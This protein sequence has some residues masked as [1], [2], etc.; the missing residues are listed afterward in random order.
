M[1]GSTTCE[2]WYSRC[3]I[4]RVHWAKA[5]LKKAALVDQ[6]RRGVIRIS[7]QGRQVVTENP[8]RVDMKY[9]ERF[10]AYAAW[11][12]GKI[13][14][15]I[16]DEP[17]EDVGVVAQTPE[18]RIETAYQELREA[19]AEDLLQQVKECS[20]KFF[21]RLV[22]ELLV[23][24]GY[25][26]S[27]EDAGKAV[28]R[29]GDGGIDG[30]IKEDRLGL[31]VVVIQAK[32]WTSNQ[33]GRPDVQSFAGSMEAYRANKGVFITTTTFSAPASEYVRQIQ[34]KI[35]LIDGPTLANLMIDHGVGVTG[36]RSFDLKR[37]DSDY[38]EE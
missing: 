30:V 33:I 34:R 37:L 7:E 26:G 17:E 28:G 24:M 2:T 31:D 22:V 14:G 19:L 29:S 15:K 9:L 38:F 20:D 4:N 13:K 10:P 5:Y 21:E 8:G 3:P 35:V 1:A 11:N 32:R 36:Y 25:G 12:R 6:V 27:I 18:E 16:E 23:R